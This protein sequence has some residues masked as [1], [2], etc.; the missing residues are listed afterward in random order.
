MS[1]EK[2]E[3]FFNTHAGTYDS[4]MLDK[5]KLD[6]F[7]TEIAGYV[8]PRGTQSRRAI[9]LRGLYRSPLRSKHSS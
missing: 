2:M 9:Y 5:L 7:Y 1:L 8:N 6:V 3:D 4:H